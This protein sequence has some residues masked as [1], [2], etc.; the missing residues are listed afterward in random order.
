[1][2]FPNPTSEKFPH[3][4]V[5]FFFRERASLKTISY[6]I[7]S[8]KNMMMTIINRVFAEKKLGERFHKGRFLYVNVWRN[9]S[10][11]PI[12]IGVV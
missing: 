7:Y 12:G 6:Y 11:T 8:V 4:P 2:G 1:M 3:F 10:D 9:I 5:F